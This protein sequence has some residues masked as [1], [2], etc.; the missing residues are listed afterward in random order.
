MN[1]APFE[2]INTF[3]S[4]DCLRTRKLL[5]HKKEIEK[6]IGLT[7]IKGMTLVPTKVYFRNSRIKVEIGVAKGKKKYDKREDLKKKDAQRKIDR[8]IKERI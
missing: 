5:L 8:S 3:Y 7:T 1:I 2:N 6:L 4:V